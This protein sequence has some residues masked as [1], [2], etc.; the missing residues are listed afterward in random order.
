MQHLQLHGCG[1]HHE[2]GRH[3]TVFNAANNHKSRVPRHREIKR[4]LVREICRQLGI[5]PPTEK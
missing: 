3:T 2:G 1:F 4:G 5:P